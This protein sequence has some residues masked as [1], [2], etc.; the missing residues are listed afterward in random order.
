M[1]AISD[2]IQ[3][4]VDEVA[5]S[6][7]GVGMF[8]DGVGGRIVET[9]AYGTSDPASH[10]FRGLT[11]RNASMF[12]PAGRAYVYRIYGAHWCFNIVGGE[13]PGCAVLI[14][15]L[16]PLSGVGEMRFKRRRTDDRE[17]CSGP[18]RLC[19]ALGITGKYDGAPLDKPPFSFVFGTNPPAVTAC[20]RVGISKGIATP[21]RFLRLNLQNTLVDRAQ[22]L[23]QFSNKLKRVLKYV[24]AALSDQLHLNG[25]GCANIDSSTMPPLPS[26]A[27]SD[28]SH[29]TLAM[30]VGPLVMKGAARSGGGVETRRHL[31]SLI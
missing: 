22:S 20:A 19:E 1:R 24:V 25:Q 5:R 27:F 14:R 3:R 2:F 26:P 31:A 15:A 23:R 13:K 29:A 7:I 18:G 30:R 4:P 11:P 21:W 8:V 17:L 16:E 12:G 10:S 6:L 28:G 9:E